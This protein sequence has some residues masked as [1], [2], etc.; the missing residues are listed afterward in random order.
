MV[1][2]YMWF[3]SDYSSR[4]S[5]DTLLS[6]MALA[7]VLNTVYCVPDLLMN[8]SEVPS[9]V[10]DKTFAS[11]VGL[12]NSETSCLN[13]HMNNHEAVYWVTTAQINMLLFCVI[14]LLWYHFAFIRLKPIQHSVEILGSLSGSCSTCTPV[15]FKFQFAF[16]VMFYHP[17]RF[18]RLPI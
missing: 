11:T 7:H 4:F 6:Q 2:Q 8:G 9:N 10:V 3:Y 14:I 17:V 13:L 5:R 1:F 18:F 16:W 15:L 12:Y